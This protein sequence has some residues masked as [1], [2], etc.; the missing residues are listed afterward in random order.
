MGETPSG[1]DGAGPLCY[2]GAILAQDGVEC[3]VESWSDG[4]VDWLDWERRIG[5]Q[6]TQIHRRF[7]TP[8]LNLRLS[9]FICVPFRSS[10]SIGA[11]RPMST[12]LNSHAP[13]WRLR[14]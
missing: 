12:D 2:T 9:A 13:P 4:L 3:R 5:T 10:Q 1:G 6:I 8:Q 14:Q 11:C 7:A